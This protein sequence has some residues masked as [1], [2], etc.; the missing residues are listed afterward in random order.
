[1]KLFQFDQKVWDFG[2][3][4]RIW[5]FFIVKNRTFFCVDYEKSDKSHDNYR[6]L[7][8]TFSL[9]ITPSY[10]ISVEFACGEISLT[11]YLFCKYFEGWD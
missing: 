7:P 1:M 3:V 5:Q 11:F 8:L 2:G 9:D 4:S 6:V 10:S